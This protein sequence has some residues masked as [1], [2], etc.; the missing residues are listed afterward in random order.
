[1]GFIRTTKVGTD[2]LRQLTSRKQA[3]EFHDVAL[4]MDPFGFNRVQPGTLGRQ[5]ERQD[6]H[7]FAR[8]LDLLIV[9]PYPGPYGLAL[10]PGGVIPDQE[11]VGL[12]LLAQTFT[13]C[14][15][16]HNT[17]PRTGW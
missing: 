1:M 15:D 11:P 8:L 17:T 7:A 6:A 16:V 14:S 4:G 3:I 9:R 5:Q 12:A 13:A 10:M 2:A